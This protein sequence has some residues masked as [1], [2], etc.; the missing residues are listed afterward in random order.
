ME[1]AYR[2]FIRDEDGR[3][4]SSN[5]INADS[6]ESALRVAGAYLDGGSVEVWDRQRLVGR[7]PPPSA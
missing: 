1:A 5:P 6:D 4:V 2:I 3:I 7:L